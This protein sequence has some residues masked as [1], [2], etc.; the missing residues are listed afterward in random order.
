MPSEFLDSS[1]ERTSGKGYICQLGYDPIYPWCQVVSKCNSSPDG[2]HYY[3]SSNISVKGELR[4]LISGASWHSVGDFCKFEVAYGLN[5][6]LEK[7][8][9]GISFQKPGE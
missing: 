7:R 2:I 4:H 8:N 6:S 1:S 5:S 3:E 9:T